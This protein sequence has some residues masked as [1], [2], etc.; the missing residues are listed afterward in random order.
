MDGVG[1]RA[2][3]QAGRVDDLVHAAVHEAA[4][5][6]EPVVDPR[7]P[8]AQRVLGGGRRQIDR[9]GSRER[10]VREDVVPGYARARRQRAAVGGVVVETIGAAA[11]VELVGDGRPT[12]VAVVVGLHRRHACGVRTV[13]GA[14]AAIRINGTTDCLTVGGPVY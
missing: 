1:D 8:V 5:G 2:Q 7:L 4:A 14:E 12:G 6:G 13:V 10:H 11:V 3:R 9:A